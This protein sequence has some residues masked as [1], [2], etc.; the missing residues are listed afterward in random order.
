MGIEGLAFVLHRYQ[1]IYKSNSFA[2][3][4]QSLSSYGVHFPETRD[5][6]TSSMKVFP[7]SS[8]LSRISES[9]ARSRSFEDED[10]DLDDGDN[11]G[12]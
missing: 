4:N 6:S 10:V 2:T 11:L 9:L 5:T 1:E 7:Y 8:G 3:S 12:V